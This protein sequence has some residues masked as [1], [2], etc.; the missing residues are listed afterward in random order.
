MVRRARSASFVAVVDGEKKQLLVQLKS[1]MS[2]E[3]HFESGN[4]D[5]DSLK[6]AI[7]KN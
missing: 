2:D 7:A 4:T 1:K 6:G 5:L 3:V